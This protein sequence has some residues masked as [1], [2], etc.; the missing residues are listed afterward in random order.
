[1]TKDK[2]EANIGSYLDFWSYLQTYNNAFNIL[3]EDIE[4]NKLHVDRIAYPTLYIARHCLE[5]GFKANIR[6]FQKY[7]EKS[8]FINSDSHNLKDLLSGFYLH[9]TVTIQNLKIKYQT[10][11]DSEDIK[12]FNEYYNAIKKFT[13][14]LDIIDRGSFSF[15]YPLD[16]NNNQVFSH[17]DKINMLDVKEALEKAMTLLKYTSSVFSKYTDYVD[18]IEKMYQDEL[19]NAYSNY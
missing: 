17:K 8:D 13:F 2:F 12:E 7:S 14:Q 11:V 1:M 6:Y 18:M 16:K 4:K 10:E 3:I 5:L 19:N 9:V 15:R